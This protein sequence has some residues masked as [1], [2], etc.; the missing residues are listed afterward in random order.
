M[1]HSSDLLKILARWLELT[2]LIRTQVR[3]H[4]GPPAESAK[5]AYSIAAAEYRIPHSTKKLVVTSP[6]RKAD[7]PVLNYSQ[8]IESSKGKI[9][10]DTEAYSAWETCKPKQ[11][12]AG[13]GRVFLDY[14][15]NFVDLRESFGLLSYRRPR[16]RTGV[17]EAQVLD[18]VLLEVPG[19]TEPL[20][21]NS[22]AAE[23]WKLC[24]NH[25]SMAE[26]AEELEKKYS[27][28]HEIVCSDVE[29]AIDQLHSDGAI[30]L[31]VAR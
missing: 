5:I 29:N 14:L 25:R 15:Q 23:I 16:K 13:V 19:K 20:S 3:S 2:G 28:P 6:E 1:I 18:Q 10:W 8:P 21:L 27:V 26:I 7:R 24:D 12:K 11:A 9:V 31:E 17:R 4:L 22:S 30:D